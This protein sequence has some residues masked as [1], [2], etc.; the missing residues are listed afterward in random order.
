MDDSILQETLIAI[1]AAI[2]KEEAAIKRGE[3]L[4]SLKLDPRFKSVILDGYFGSEADK[5]FEILTDPT[6]ASCYTEDQIRLKLASISDFK[7]YT[8]TA[9][10]KGTVEVEAELAPDKIERDR[11]YRKEITEEYSHLE[12]E[13]V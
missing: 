4:A 2:A 1:D 7:A 6:G 10:H 13:E 8:G 11:I 3:D 12:V 9:D 5:L